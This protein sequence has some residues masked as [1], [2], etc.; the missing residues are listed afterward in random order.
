M[1]QR[2]SYS[3]GLYSRAAAATPAGARVAATWTAATLPAE[4]A[5]SFVSEGIGGLAG[6]FGDEALGEPV[7][8][9]DLDVETDT[10][11]VRIRVYNRGIGLMLG[12]GP[13]LVQL[14]RFFSTTQA[15]AKGETA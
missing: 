10:G 2:L 8:V 4:V 12:M 15:A 5:A 13:E 3:W 9:D 6:T 11:R 7:E 1:I 14:H